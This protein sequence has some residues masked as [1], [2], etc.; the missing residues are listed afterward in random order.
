LL[1]LTSSLAVRGF[2]DNDTIGFQTFTDP[3]NDP[4]GLRPADLNGLNFFTVRID[5]THLTALPK[6]TLGPGAQIIPTFGVTG[7]RMNLLRLGIP[8]TPTGP[9]TLP[10]GSPFPI[11]EAFVQ[12]G[13]NLL[14]LTNFRRVDT[15]AAFL[16][17]D[18]KTAVF[19]ASAD[20][21]PRGTNAHENC[22][23]FSV[24]VL[25]GVPRQITHL[26]PGFRVPSGPGC[27]LP[28]GIGYG[29]FRAV[30]QY[31]VTR[32]I[33]FDTTLDALKLRFLDMRDEIFAIRPDGGGLRQL[34]EAACTVAEPD[35]SVR[36]ELPGPFAYSTRPN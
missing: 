24:N 10:L 2:V 23:L 4:G 14:Q 1:L 27:Y 19:L 3:K 34:T 33:V 20:P 28:F 26:D 9:P 12:D 18:R 7:R 35:G 6:A 11:T 31:P 30:S 17:A 16:A 32:T 21:D 36:V 8:G 25:G 15:F 29:I 5:G 13:K 22:Q